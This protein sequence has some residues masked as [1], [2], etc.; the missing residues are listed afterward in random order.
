M[1]RRSST[2]LCSPRGALAPVEAM[3]AISRLLKA[4]TMNPRMCPGHDVFCKTCEPMVLS[5]DNHH[6]CMYII[7]T[8]IY[9]YTQTLRSLPTPGM[10]VV[11]LLPT[12]TIC[13]KNPSQE[14]GELKRA[15]RPPCRP[16]RDL[17]KRPRDTP[18]ALV[19]HEG[20][21]F[22]LLGLPGR[23]LGQEA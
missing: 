5:T 21:R 6:V 10:G 19:E 3:L 18:G 7:Y 17:P 15:G 2:P 14:L 16:L 12:V 13:Q 8:Y 4:Q 9:I 11:Q 22:L 1:C 23:F 20:K